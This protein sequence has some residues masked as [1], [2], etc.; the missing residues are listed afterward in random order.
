MVSEKQYALDWIEKNKKRI[1]EISDQ[2]WT[3]AELGLI[4]TKSSMVL[5]NELEKYGFIVKRG[6][7]D[8]PTA[9][10][11]IWGE[12]SPVIGIMGEYDALPGLSQKK[13]PWKEPLDSGKPGHGCGHNIHG[14]SG[15]TAAITLKN[16]M[17]KF[18]VQG[19]IKYFGCPAEENFNGKVYLVREGYFKDVDV[20]LSHHPCIMN[21]VSLANSIAV[22]SVKFHFYGIASHAAA[23]PEQGRSALDAIELMNVGVNFLREHVAQD[24][25]IHYIIEKGGEQPNI[26][27]PHA[28]S[29]YY[30]RA[31]ERDQVEFVYNWILD[32]AEHAR[33]RYTNIQ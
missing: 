9:F 1:I 17:Q 28:Q 24:V 13:V 22:N 19:T 14:T 4:E 21:T 32:I 18:G 8:M 30:I 5:A 11:A 23:S 6:I 25:R 16:V 27:P 33:N 3:F 15:M 29:W 26:V 31:P 2:I 10:I 7:A 12:S 20:A